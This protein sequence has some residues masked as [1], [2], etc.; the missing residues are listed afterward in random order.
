MIFLKGRIL[1][2]FSKDMDNIDVNVPQYLNLWLFHMAFVAATLVLISYSTPIFLVVFLPLTIV[3]VICQVKD[4]TCFL[5]LSDL[6][7]CV[8]GQYLFH[9]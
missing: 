7:I 3:F 6:F 4:V 9:L 5:V 8:L 1:N 2:R